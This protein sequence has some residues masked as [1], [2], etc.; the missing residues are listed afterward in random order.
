MSHA[1]GDPAWVHKALSNVL[2]AHCEPDARR[3]FIGGHKMLDTYVGHLWRV[4][5]EQNDKAAV[6]AAAAHDG[7]VRLPWEDP[8]S[9]E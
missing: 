6:F 8:P 7:V 4:T 1:F 5:H 9:N 3:V 2:A